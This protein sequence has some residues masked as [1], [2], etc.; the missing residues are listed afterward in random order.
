[1]VEHDL[2]DDRSLDEPLIGGQ[3]AM[4]GPTAL[5]SLR[6][7]IIDARQFRLPERPGPRLIEN[8]PSGQLATGVTRSP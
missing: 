6:Q 5:M 1:V 3:A 7:L 2:Q 4:L 8:R